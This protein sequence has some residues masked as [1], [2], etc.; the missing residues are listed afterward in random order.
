MNTLKSYIKV[1]MN[2]NHYKIGNLKPNFAT[3][4][5]CVAQTISSK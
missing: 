2:I 3:Q 4:L 5:K 1:F